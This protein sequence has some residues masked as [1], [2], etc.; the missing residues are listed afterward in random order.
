MGLL[1]NMGDAIDDVDS[2]VERF[3]DRCGVSAGI[4]SV[5]LKR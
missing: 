3:V 1:Y 2:G 4:E 5:I